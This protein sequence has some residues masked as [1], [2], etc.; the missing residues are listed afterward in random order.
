MIGRQMKKIISSSLLIVFVLFINGCSALKEGLSSSMEV[1]TLEKQINRVSIGMTI[2]RQNKLM[3]EEMEISA[4][5]LW[6]QKMSRDIDRKRKHYLSKLL[7]YDPYFATVKYTDI[8]QRDMLGF[9]KSMQNKK[10]G[11]KFAALI[12]N[13]KVS[14]ITYTA[15]DK[16]EILYGEDTKNWPEIFEASNS[17]DFNSTKTRDIEAIKGDVYSN[18]G[19]AIL[20]LTP[21]NF[22][23]D[24]ELAHIEMQE[25][26]SLVLSL[27]TTEGNLKSKLENGTDEASQIKD[28]L[29]VLD[30]EVDDAQRIADEKEQIYFTLLDGAKIALESD[31][32]LNDVNYIH[33]AENINR[34]SKEIASSSWDTYTL[35][36]IA[37]KKI[38]ANQMLS[39]L[40]LE[41]ESLARAKLYVPMPLQKKYNRR[42]SR[43]VKNSLYVLPNIFTGSYYTYKQS[44]VAKK[45][46]EFTDVIIEAYSLK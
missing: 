27:K 12:L 31:I 45:Y 30:V 22:Q 24:L 4:D 26:V 44:K 8:I 1:P 19:E 40:S 37:L 39:N 25:S 10:D 3:L 9:G 20:S 23:K 15:I 36:G 13:K 14:P 16:I 5:A 32:N 42:I 11:V 18:I 33:L 21:L 2:V 29:R 34:V 46:R 17:L 41:L 38:E 7:N 6:P 43:L 35:F 28:K